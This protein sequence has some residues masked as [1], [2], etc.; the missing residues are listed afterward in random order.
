M[1][2]VKR[3]LMNGLNNLKRSNMEIKLTYIT[4]E[5]AKLN[6]VMSNILCIFVV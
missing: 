5:Q 4:F 3:L 6:L 2:M 1:V